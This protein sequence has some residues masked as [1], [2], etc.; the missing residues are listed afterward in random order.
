MLTAILVIL[1]V[2]LFVRVIALGSNGTVMNL[3][4]QIEMNTRG[5]GK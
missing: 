1:S 4:K 3:L 2:D 5:Y